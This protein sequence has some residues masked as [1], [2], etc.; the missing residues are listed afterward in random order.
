VWIS[1]LE[2]LNRRGVV[3][4]VLSMVIEGVTQK[5]A[6]KLLGTTDRQIKNLVVR[7]KAPGARSGGF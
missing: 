4:E 1:A 5:Q 3:E 2:M 7:R 6:A